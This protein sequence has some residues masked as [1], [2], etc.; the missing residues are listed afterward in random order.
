M[1]YDDYDWATETFGFQYVRSLNND[2]HSVKET[3][4][5]ESVEALDHIFFMGNTQFLQKR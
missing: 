4:L 5:P 1:R 3:K 2:D